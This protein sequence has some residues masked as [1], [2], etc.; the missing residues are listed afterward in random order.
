MRRIYL[1]FLLVVVSLLGVSCSEDRDFTGSADLTIDK[2]T[3][4]MPIANFVFADGVTDVLGTNV[5]QTLS[6]KVKGNEVKQYTIGYGKDFEEMSAAHPFGE[7]F[8]TQVDLEFV[9]TIDAREEFVAVCGV[10]TMSE[11]GE[12]SIAATFTGKMLRKDHALSLI[13]GNLTPEAVQN[14][15]RTF[16]GQ[17][18]AVP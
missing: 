6:V 1:L 17:F 4:H 15:L 13:G 9:S 18:V 8:A 2:T 14:S 12:D 7:G 5:S 10:L 11:Y 16:S 3:Y